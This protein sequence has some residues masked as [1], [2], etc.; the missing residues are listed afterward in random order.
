MNIL[1]EEC[2]IEKLL[3]PEQYNMY[4]STQEYADNNVNGFKLPI[5]I[6][7]DKSY[8]QSVEKKLKEY[9]AYISGKIAFNKDVELLAVIQRTNN[10]ILGAI[11][12]YLCGN[13]HSAQLYIYDVLKEYCT[14][15]FIVTE[16]DKSYAF[17]GIAPHQDIRNTEYDYSAMLQTELSFFRARKSI[18]VLAQA[19]EMSHIPL[20][21][22]EL[23]P[24]AR[25]SI[26]GVP[27]LYL[28]TTSYCC[29]LEL[30]RP[31][32]SQF[33]CSSLKATDTGKKLHILNLAISEG[34]INGVFNRACEKDGSRQHELQRKMMMIFPLIIA[35]SYCVKQKERNFKSEYIV[36]QLVMQNLTKLKIDGIAY[37]S[38]KS[39]SDF[40]YPH[41]VNLAIP[42]TAINLENINKSFEISH[43][44]S[45]E[46]FSMLNEDV[47][48]I[49]RKSFINANFD[50]GFT[51]EIS[52]NS[53]RMPYKA[54]SFS[55]F[56]DFLVNNEHFDL[57]K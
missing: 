45:L 56:D 38:K 18:N 21:K 20:D 28:G 1:G 37:I 19:Q 2:G 4:K 5:S 54:I 8:R 12:E 24:T 13:I 36:S 32:R 50:T 40:E 27:C 14:D 22:R 48:E 6:S 51:G 9:Y 7:E 10:S 11:D 43:P 34:L 47:V 16:L 33:Y 53:C 3:S 17:R 57:E 41:N 29:W 31:S 46:F 26:A 25:F 35:T 23:V 52:L 30:E 44:S 55:N 39:Y 15:D 42:V 49:K